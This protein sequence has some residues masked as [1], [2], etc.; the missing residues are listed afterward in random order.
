MI[1]EGHA[2]CIMGNH[3]LNAILYHTEGAD[4]PLRPRSDKNSNQHQ[5]FL[6]EFPIDD[7]I[8]L[9][10][11]E[12]FKTLPLA[13]DLGEFRIVHACWY[14][15]SLDA[16]CFDGQSVFLDCNN[17]EAAADETGE[18]NPVAMLLKGP[19]VPLPAGYSFLDI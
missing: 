10:V 15:P 1:S 17:L 8:T 6:D 7:P 4:G 11:I 16:L 2:Q 18:E 14:Q 5:T 9:E 12:F 19:E 3:E 13:M